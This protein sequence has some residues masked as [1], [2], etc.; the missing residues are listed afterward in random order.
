MTAF[1]PARLTGM[2]DVPAPL[3]GTI[4][5]T[6]S[7][8]TLTAPHMERI[9]ETWLFLLACAAIWIIP[10]RIMVALARREKSRKPTNPPPVRLPSPKQQKKAQQDEWQKTF[11]ELL[12]RTCTKH[13]YDYDRMRDWW[14]CIHCEAEEEWT[15][16]GGCACFVVYDG[17]VADHHLV[18]TERNRFCTIHGRGPAVRAIQ[19]FEKYSKGGITS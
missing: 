14:K 13:E 3:G 19:N 6:P 7:L 11:L 10:W 5:L 4:R 16:S 15:Y 17:T 2:Q 1:G 12:Q 8:Q 9:M 18:L